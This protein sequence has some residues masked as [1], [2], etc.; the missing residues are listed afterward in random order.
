MKVKEL[1]EILKSFNPEAIVVCGEDVGEVLEV[2]YDTY[3]LEEY[4][5]KY[6]I[7]Q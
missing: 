7:L 5:E 1:I 3:L 6:V 4:K 2:E